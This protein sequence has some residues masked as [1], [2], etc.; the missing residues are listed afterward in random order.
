MLRLIIKY[1]YHIRFI[2]WVFRLR[3]RVILE[4]KPLMR[5]LLVTP[6]HP[7]PR[8]LNVCVV[9]T[10]VLVLSTP[11]QGAPQPRPL[12]D[13]LGGYHPPPDLTL[14]TI[15]APATQVLDD[16][17]SLLWSCQ[18]QTEVILSDPPLLGVAPLLGVVT[19]HAWTCPHT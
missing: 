17:G 18:C 3:G 15:L 13:T 4:D 7:E 10:Q 16:G 12:S 6:P 2:F 11:Q 14:Q 9:Q 19:L 8:P 5:T 1:K